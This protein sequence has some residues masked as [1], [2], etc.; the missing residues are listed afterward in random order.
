MD[1]TNKPPTR[2]KA[3][4]PSTTK[5]QPY[6]LKHVPQDFIVK[7]IPL[8]PARTPLEEGSHLLAELTK[9]NK[10]TE[11]VLAELAKQLRL[12][13]KA[14]GIA[15]L[16]D[17]R[18][19]TTQYIT[20]RGVTTL[21][22]L[23]IPGV[24][25]TPQGFLNKPLTLGDL[26]GNAFSI[27][28]RN[29]DKPLTFTPPAYLVNYFDEQRFSHLNARIGRSLIRKEWQEACELI[30]RNNPRYR[31]ALHRRLQASPKDY[32]GAL[33]ILPKQVLRIF[34]H[35]YPSYLFNELTARYLQK[36][37]F[38][39][40]EDPYSLGTLLFPQ[41]ILAK[42]SSGD[43]KKVRELA[44]VLLPLPGFDLASLREKIP[45][46]AQT[47][48][49]ELLAEEGISPRDFIIPQ[50]ANL[51]IEGSLRSILAP[52]TS[53]SQEPS[54]P[55]PYFSGTFAKKISFTL[56]KGSYATMLIRQLFLE[57]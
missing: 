14:I 29:L 31:S 19:I 8:P 18:A 2:N 22:P 7:E 35:A 20:I 26:A 9:E 27:T 13:R 51:S 57:V 12:P 16:K 42:N 48:L 52:V 39:L 1:K 33:S 34:L 56:P 10:E 55:D 46:Q 32:T 25:I 38:R 4:H 54:Q 3:E 40:H 30:M 49:D 24:T 17:K 28:L 47:L 50:L 43:H 53:F 6:L 15:G 11:D 45:L 37:G 21:P 36:K 44:N 23:T 5:N 41:H